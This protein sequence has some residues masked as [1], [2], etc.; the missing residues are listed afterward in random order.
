VTANLSFY[1]KKKYHS[2]SNVSQLVLYQF[3]TSIRA[4][5]LFQ[6]YGLV[7]MLLWTTDDEKS[8]LMP[9]S[10]QR[11]T[12]F[13]IEAELNTEYI[14]EV[15]GSDGTSVAGTLAANFFRDRAIDLESTRD[16]LSRMKAA[17]ISIPPGRET[18]IVRDLRA[19]SPQRRNAIRAGAKPG[20]F[21]RPFRAELDELEAAFTSG[22]YSA[23]DAAQADRL[24][25]LRYQAGWEEK[26][27][28]RIHDLLTDKSLTPAELDAEMQGLN[29]YLRIEAFLARD[30]RHVFRQDPR[31]LTWDRRPVEPLVARPAEFFPSVPCALLDV[32][33]KAVHPLLRENGPGSG[34]GG[35]TFTMLLSSLMRSSVGPLSKALESIYPGAAE[36]VMPNCPSLRVDGGR[37][38]GY[39]EL[40]PR[41]LNERQIIE[42]L[43]AWMEWPFRPEFSALVARESDDSGFGD[44]EGGSSVQMGDA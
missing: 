38:P 29:K 30:N 25:D 19:M 16:V 34:R 24:K 5:S 20:T 21:L 40:T 28:K 22:K 33:P 35:D 11:R 3:I 36:G 44:D 7:R 17:R 37:A 1:P 42:I 8:S 41:V 10:I 18:Q 31:V 13:S 14:A 6:K 43:R 9:R 32:Q 27:Q 4:Q 26:R 12:R 2:F 39:L 15:A 23:A